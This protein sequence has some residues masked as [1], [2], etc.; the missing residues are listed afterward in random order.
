MRGGNIDLS[1]RLR[2]GLGGAKKRSIQ[3]KTIE[4]LVQI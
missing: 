3:A 1:R 2:P 4:K